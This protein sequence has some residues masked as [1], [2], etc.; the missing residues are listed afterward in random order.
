VGGEEGWSPRERDPAREGAGDIGD[1]EMS[2]HLLKEKMTG[3]SRSLT[4]VAKRAT[5][6]GM[7]FSFFFAF[8]RHG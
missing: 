8:W 6:F 2:P 4:P 3:K 5:G 1:G 7:T